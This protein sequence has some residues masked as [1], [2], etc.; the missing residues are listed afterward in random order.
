MSD[1]DAKMLLVE[2]TLNSLVAVVGSMEYGQDETDT[3]APLMRGETQTS[4]GYD[5]VFDLYDVVSDP[6]GDDTVKVRGDT[7]NNLVCIS[8]AW[9]EIVGGSHELDSDITIT[10][11]TYIYVTV[12]RVP[13]GTD[14]A[15]LNSSGTKP[16]GDEDEEHYLLW[17]I[18]FYDS[19]ITASGI[20]RYRSSA[21]HITTFA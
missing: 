8:G 7:D 13:A 11:D 14:T 5:S 1:L 3:W 18:P 9:I 19:Q 16:T 21:I 10:A 15:K 2:S 20:L 4:S 12:K 6:D 17:Y